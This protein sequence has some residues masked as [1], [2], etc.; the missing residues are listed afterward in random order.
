MRLDQLFEV[1]YGNKLDM[2]KMTPAKPSDGVAFVG[3]KG[4][5]E[6]VSGYVQRIPALEPYDAGLLTVALGGSRLLA[7]FVQQRDF[8]TAQNV[9]VL[10]PRFEMSL[11]EK[12]YYAKSIQHNRFRYSAFGREANRSLRTLELPD[13]VPDWLHALSIEEMVE[14][15]KLFHENIP[16]EHV[17]PISLDTVPLSS[18]FKIEYGHS[19]QLNRL[20]ETEQPE[21]VNYISRTTKNNGI[22]ARVLLPNDIKPAPGHTLSVALSATPLTTFYQPEPYVTGYHV[23]VLTPRRKM[24][25]AEL[26]W[27]KV[28]IEA[29]RYRYSYGRQANRTLNTL[30]VPARP[31][32]IVN[33]AVNIATAGK[34]FEADSTE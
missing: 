31:P 24:G 9:A 4:S 15:P 19:L 14:D 7:T 28:V 13:V 27:W 2:N 3:R 16:I 17:S 26:L 29:N 25:L 8:Y 30:Q 34:L 11:L 10:E 21:G 18:I 33:Q 5:D 6:G 32:H 1:E 12:L 20:N 23:A 22:A